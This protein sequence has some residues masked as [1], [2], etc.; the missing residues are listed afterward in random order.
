MT[1]VPWHMSFLEAETC[2]R[3]EVIWQ[4]ARKSYEESLAIL[5]TNWREASRR[6]N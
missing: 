4:A 6:G 5:Q 1:K 2:S 3:I